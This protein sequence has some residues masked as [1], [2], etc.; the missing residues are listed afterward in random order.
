MMVLVAGGA[1]CAP[2]VNIEEERDAV[3]AADRDWSQSGTDIDTFMSFFASDA[4]AYPQGMPAVKGADAIRTTFTEMS[5]APG[6]SLAWTAER[7]EVAGSGDAA[8][9]TGTYEMSMGGAKDKGKYVTI[10]RKQTDGSWKATED[11]F[12][13]DMSA[14]GPPAEHVM[15]APSAIKWGDAPP[16][17]PA[18]ARAAVIS[19]DPMQA[20]PFVVRLQ[21]PAGYRIARHWHPTT[22]NLTV[23]SGTVAIGMGEKSTS[24]QSR[25]CPPAGS[26]SFLRK[27]GTTSCRRRRRPSRSMAW[28][29]L[30]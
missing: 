19:G 20:Q 6:F 17:L 24:R 2:S 12:N 23:L 16:M 7:A 26:V 14:G 4:T 13:S 22:E 27:C 5:K 8:Y 15:L 25:I 10:W 21:V 9:T 3:L 11:I 1:G 29:R 30:P 28:A 18:G